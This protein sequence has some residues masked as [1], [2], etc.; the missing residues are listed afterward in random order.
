MGRQRTQ[1]NQINFEKKYK[2][3]GLILPDFNIYCYKATLLKTVL[4]WHNERYIEQWNG[5]GGPEINHYI[6]GHLTFDKGAKAI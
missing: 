6:Y 2:T 4:F 1:K 3:G 5:I